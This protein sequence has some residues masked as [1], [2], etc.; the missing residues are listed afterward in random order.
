M[1]A[2]LLSLTRIDIK[3]L[4]IT[5]AYSLHRVV[6]SLFD[7]V[8]T[9]AE[10]SASIPSGILYVDKGASKNDNFNSRKILLLSNRKPN[11]PDFGELLFRKVPEN[12]LEH[13]RYRFEVVINPT[14]RDKITA[15]IVSIKGR[16]NIALWFIEK[17]EKNWGFIVKSESLQIIHCGV[18]AFDKKGNSVTQG[19]ATLQ[20]EFVVTQREKFKASFKQGIGRGR[21]FGFGLLQ[22]VPITDPFGF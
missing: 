10:K 19:S 8:R 6:Y 22:I 20:G 15:K 17:S 2:G 12:F 1:I 11:T 14:K 9:E 18:R 3:N 4:K 13:D 5:D 16:D 7:D 21:A